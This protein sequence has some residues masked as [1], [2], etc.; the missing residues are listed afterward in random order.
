MSEY[1]SNDLEV[2]N[3]EE[4]EHNNQ[5]YNQKEE[6]NNIS[7]QNNINENNNNNNENEEEEQEQENENENINES[8]NNNNNFLSNENINNN[9]DYENN[10]NI[11]NTKSQ[12]TENSLSQNNNNNN[13]MNNSLTKKSQENLEEQEENPEILYEEFFNYF[14][15][16]KRNTL[17]IKE[18]KNA[19][20]CLGLV[21][22]EREIQNFLEIKT[23]TGKEKINLEEFKYICNK[24]LNDNGNNI[25]ELE[26]AFE[27]MDPEKTGIVDSRMLRHQMKI[28][29]PKITEEE[30]N[31][32]LSEFGE[33]EDGNINY[34]EYLKNLKI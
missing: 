16:N 31:Q 5:D 34:K 32:I 2:E 21:V 7:S 17:S 24:K 19:M 13:N 8:E 28:F 12:H 26:E 15:P 23:K 27:L 11:K 18:C 20:R 30:I 22:T 9:N 6:N 29:K 14:L 10:N 33:D 4:E 1:E 3:W 25:T